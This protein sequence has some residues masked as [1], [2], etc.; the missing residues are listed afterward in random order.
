MTSSVCFH[1]R[2]IWAVGYAV[3]GLGATSG[4]GCRTKCHKLALVWMALCPYINPARLSMAAL[5]CWLDCIYEAVSGV[6]W[7]PKLMVVMLRLYFISAWHYNAKVKW[8]TWLSFL[9]KLFSEMLLL[10]SHRAVTLHIFV[11]IRRFCR[12]WNT[13]D[14]LCLV[15]FIC[16]KFE[17]KKS[18]VFQS[19]RKS[20]HSNKNMPCH[21]LTWVMN[22]GKSVCVF[23]LKYDSLCFKYD[24]FCFFVNTLLKMR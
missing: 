12:L 4:G 17:L 11:R 22:I 8:G 19:W 21:S 13:I 7:V 9:L 14:V 24:P 15:Y 2:H 10:M 6:H 18:I 20:T 5:L 1:G 23:V 3:C 16:T